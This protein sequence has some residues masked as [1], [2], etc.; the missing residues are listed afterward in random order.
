MGALCIYDK[1][2]KK[3]PFKKEAILQN[4]RIPLD[5][6]V[7]KEIEKQKENS[8]C[9]IINGN[10]SIGTG[11]L[12]LIPYP[13]KVN[14]IPVLITCNHVIN[15]DEKE[16]K[17]IFNDQLEKILTLN[18]NR[19]IYKNDEKDVTIIE[20][21]NTDN[22]NYNNMLEIDYDIFEETDL[23]EKF[24]NVYII[25]FPLGKESS[26][27][28]DIIEKIENDLIE[29][30]CS[31]ENGSSGAPIIN[32][33]NYKVIGIHKGFD[34]NLNLNI[35]IL[36]KEPINDFKKIKNENTEKI[37]L[38][39]NVNKY[40]GDYKNNKMEGKGILYYNNGNRYEGDFKIGLQEGKGI[41]YYIDGDKYEGDFK[42]G[43]ME[44]KGN[45]YY[46]N[47]NRYEGDYKND[48]MEGKGNFY[49]NNGDRYEGDFKNNKKEG[50]GN[51]YYINGNRYEGDF[52]NDYIEGKGILYYN[53]GDR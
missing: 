44:G 6:K 36:L 24:K 28:Y 37:I 17:L 16:V 29:H 40:E 9:K 47:G 53:D 49:S 41:L 19:K 39:D 27:S 46:K 35:G 25:H 43:K 14:Q 13:D 23:N 8:I 10:I 18:N 52:K 38:L 30:K 45:F 5:F 12:S 7:I 33:N 4:N 34:L 26:L 2:R 22:F 20:I 51:L 1:E 15:G 48:M 11:F 3:K 21:K 31:T 50:K 42:N 32:L